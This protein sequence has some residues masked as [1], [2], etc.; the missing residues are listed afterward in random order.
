MARYTPLGEGK[1][2]FLNSR[3]FYS[4]FEYLTTDLG[5]TIETKYCEAQIIFQSNADFLKFETNFMEFSEEKI[6]A[7]LTQFFQRLRYPLF[8]IGNYFLQDHVQP[9]PL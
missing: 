7:L 3:Y 2:Y 5:L 6:Q 9:P 4:A 1:V 8:L